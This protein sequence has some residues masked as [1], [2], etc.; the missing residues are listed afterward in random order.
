M[1][2]VRLRSL[3][4]SLLVVIACQSWA[5]LPLSLSVDLRDAPRKLLHATEIVPVQNGPL[6]LAFPEWIRNEHEPAP[7]TQQ[8]GLFIRTFDG[9]GAAGEALSWKRDPLDLYL[10]HVTIPNGVRSIEVRFDFITSDK[11]GGT[12]ASSDANLAVLDWNTVVLYPYSGRDTQVTN[13]TVTPTVV[14]PNGWHTATSLKTLASA[15]EPTSSVVNFQPVSLEQLVDSPMIAGRYFREIALAPEVSPKHY[16]DIVADHPEDLEVPQARIDELSQTIRQTG[17]LFRSHH[18]DEYRFLIT[19][20]NNI[21]GAAIDH[22]Q[23]LDNR[24]R[25]NFFRNEKRQ[26]LF[27]NYTIHDFLHSWNGKYRRPEGLATP[28]FQTPVIT[29][30][31]WVYEGL[32]DYLSNVMTVRTGSASKEEYLDALASRAAYYDR[33]PG[34]RWRDLDD[35]DTMAYQLWSS[36]DSSYD[37]WRLG[38]FDFYS[39]GNLIWLDVDVTLRNKSNGKKSL[40][41]FAALFYGLGG[42]TGPNVVPYSFHDIVACLNQVVPN[43][44]AGFLSERLHALSKAPLQG[45][46]GAGYKLVYKEGADDDFRYSLAMSIGADGVISDV[47]MGEIAYQAGFGPGMKILA[48]NGQPF[49]RATLQQAID[50]AKTTTTPIDFKVDNTGVI[51][52]L[53][54]DYHGGQ[55]HPV[56]ERIP[57]TP[58]RIAEILQPMSR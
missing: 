55:R 7:L 51:S 30:G 16:L 33:R 18:Y 1:F 3:F 11:G 56:L 37:N 20:S 8:V 43:D 46:A 45:I 5:Q 29:S 21:S 6:T 54:L 41:D 14:L 27:A 26:K 47:L 53:R 10:Y 57:N 24:R 40:N 38:G 50:A 9:S 35:V 17:L 44:W 39:E 22:L 36:E 4:L 25:A 15:M 23:S 13:F 31:M 48:V 49:A 2:L 42:D 32:T 52:D 28:N 58:D 19:L 12:L 34:M